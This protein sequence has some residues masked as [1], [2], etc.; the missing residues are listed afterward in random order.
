[1]SS[2]KDSKLPLKLGQTP[3]GSPR[4]LES[5]K[6]LASLFGSYLAPQAHAGPSRSSDSDPGYGLQDV[7]SEQNAEDVSAGA[8]EA[9]T[10]A[11]GPRRGPGNG[12]WSWLS[13]GTRI[14]SEASGSAL[15]PEDEGY[16]S[17]SDG[18]AKLDTNQSLEEDVAS[19]AYIYD[20]PDDV[21]VS[22]SSSP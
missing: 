21:C 14:P 19:L 9:P 1:M 17:I 2:S 18:V 6:K 16:Q 22:P 5:R 3:V 10:D 20:L 8:V 11:G 4:T 12:I 13:N 15:S 7:P